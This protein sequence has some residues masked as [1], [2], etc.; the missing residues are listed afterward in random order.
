VGADDRAGI[1]YRAGRIEDQDPVAVAGDQ[2]RRAAI[3]DAAA[4]VQ[5]DALA[6]WAGG[7]DRAGIDDADRAAVAGDRAAAGDLDRAGAGVVEV[8][9][10]VE[11]DRTPRYP[12][13]VIELGSMTIEPEPMI[14]PELLK[15]PPS[16]T[17]VPLSVSVP[18]LLKVPD[19]VRVTPLAIVLLPAITQLAPGSIVTVPKLTNCVPSPVSVPVVAAEASSMMLLS[20]LPP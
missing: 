7:R 20:P 10:G 15:V 9:A 6:A 2:R 17:S 13:L 1:A 4:V 14:V 8:A 5:I 3:G 16:M 11:R 18:L 12:L 19:S